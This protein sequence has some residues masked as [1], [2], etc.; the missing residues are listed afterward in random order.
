MSP[1]AE[2]VRDMVLGHA[3]F[4][5]SDGTRRDG[6]VNTYEAEAQVDTNLRYGGLFREMATESISFDLVYE[7][8][9]ASQSPGTPCIYLKVLSD[10]SPGLVAQLRSRVWNHGRIPTLWIISPHGVRIYNAFAR[11]DDRDGDDWSRHLLG[12]LRVIGDELEDMEGFHKRNF[13]DGSFWYSG[14]G[15]GIDTA[16]RVDQA[17][18]RDLQSTEIFSPEFLLANSPDMR[19]VSGFGHFYATKVFLRRGIASNG[20]PPKR[21]FPIEQSA[22]CH[23]QFTPSNSRHS[24]IRTAQTPSSTPRSTHRWKVRWMVLSSPRSLGKWFHW[25]ELRIRKMM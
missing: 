8:P 11:P 2:Q 14:N 7:T 21:A 16:Q 18:L 12:Q 9:S 23:S 4:L 20:A 3:G 10:P 15:R 5:R 22:D 6:L 24:S 17:L 19:L 25:Q 13:D 1:T